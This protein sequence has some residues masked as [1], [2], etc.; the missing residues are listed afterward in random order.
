MKPALQRVLVV[1][2]HPDSAEIAC[3]LLGLYGYTARS[4]T[5]GVAALRIA[6]EFEPE[7]GILDIGLPD[8]SGYEIARTL[9]QRYAGR[10]LYLAAITGWGQPEDIS[11]AYAA[12]FDQHVLKPADGTKI[13]DILDRANLSVRRG[14]PA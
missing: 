1:D 8:L 13:R 4:A 14:A 3:T 5:T 7:I 10:P 6:E 2:D 9:R 11:R 12:G